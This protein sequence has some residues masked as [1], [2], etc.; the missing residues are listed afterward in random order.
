LLNKIPAH[1]EQLAALRG[2]L[3][4]LLLNKIPAHVEQG[5]ATVV[6]R[7]ILPLLLL[8][9]KLGIIVGSAVLVYL[10]PD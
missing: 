2:V 10:E 5:R 6:S 7:D 1:V 8:N 3:E 9:D 4:V